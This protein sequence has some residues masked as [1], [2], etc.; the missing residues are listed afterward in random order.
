MCHMEI[1]K[2][3]LCPIL[4]V[5]DTILDKWTIL[6]LRN[7]TLD[8]AHRFQDF[9]NVFDISPTTLSKKLKLLEDNNIIDRIVIDGRPPSTKYQLSELGLQVKPMLKAIHK[10]GSK[11][12]IK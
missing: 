6:I 7:M 12:P 10:F 8:G 3:P 11:L 5:T 4:R 2:R 1:K 9:L